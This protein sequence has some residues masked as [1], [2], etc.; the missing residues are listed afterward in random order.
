MERGKPSVR[1]AANNRSDCLLAASRSAQTLLILEILS[2]GLV[3]RGKPTVVRGAANTCSDCILAA[4]GST[5]T[6]LLRIFFSVS[7]PYRKLLE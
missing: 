5:K 3:E 6:L 7:V 2:S 1:R 4:L